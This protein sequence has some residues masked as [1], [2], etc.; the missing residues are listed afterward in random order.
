MIQVD[1]KEKKAWLRFLARHVDYNLCILVLWISLGFMPN[2]RE[3]L[4]P[5][6]SVLIPGLVWVIPESLFITAMGTT[7]GKAVLGISVYQPDG[8]KLPGWKSFSRSVGVWMNGM[9]MQLPV[10]S[11]LCNLFAYVSLTK[12]GSTT[13]DANGNVNIVYDPVDFSSLVICIAFVILVPFVG[14][15]IMPH[16]FLI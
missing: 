16:P 13:W 10:V 4:P 14:I 3:N 9:G 2:I 8:K 7:P 6:T 1:S 5:L 15:L 12:H 11:L